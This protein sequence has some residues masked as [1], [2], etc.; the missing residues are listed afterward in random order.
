VNTSTWTPSSA[1]AGWIS[2]NRS[3]TSA[4][5]QSRSPAAAHIM[6]P[7]HPFVAGAVLHHDATASA[8]HSPSNGPGTRLRADLLVLPRATNRR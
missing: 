3:R 6:G 7:R 5:R 2:E 1:S 4:V 8:N